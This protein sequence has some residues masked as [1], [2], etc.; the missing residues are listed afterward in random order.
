MEQPRREVGSKRE[1]ESRGFQKVVEKLG[2]T[3]EDKCFRKACL[4]PFS[5]ECRFCKEHFCDEHIRAKPPVSGRKVDCLPEETKEKIVQEWEDKSGHQCEGYLDEWLKWKPVTLKP[6]RPKKSRLDKLLSNKPLIAAIFILALGAC[7]IYFRNDIPLMQDYIGCADGTLNSHC[8]AQKPMYCYRGE[9]VRN[10][11]VCGCPAGYKPMENQCVPG[12]TCPDGTESGA[13]SAIKPFYCDNGNLVDRASLCGCPEFFI[14]SWI[15]SSPTWNTTTRFLFSN[16]KWYKSDLAYA[17]KGN[18]TDAQAQKM[19]Q[20]VST[21]MS[22]IN[23]SS[24]LRIREASDTCPDIV[25]NCL[26]AS[27]MLNYENGVADYDVVR[28]HE[29][30]Y[31]LI[32]SSQIY[33]TLG[34]GQCPRPNVQIHELLHTLGFDHSLDPTDTISEKFG[35]LQELKNATIRDLIQIYPK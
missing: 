13:C 16:P 30:Y 18:C 27:S 17:L 10:P 23:R 5:R 24:S 28:S 11:A 4:K 14:P 1:E 12:A 2:A 25:V 9:I 22:A 6:G 29:G 21:L 31:S 19:R 35:C 20:A 26:N 15:N 32:R 33:L 7:I 3:P 8:S 34:D